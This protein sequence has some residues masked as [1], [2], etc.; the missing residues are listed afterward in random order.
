MKEQ[1][2]AIRDRALNELES[3]TASNEK[4]SQNLEEFKV[5]YLGYNKTNKKI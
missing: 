5:K 1:L 2:Q 4:L 3:I